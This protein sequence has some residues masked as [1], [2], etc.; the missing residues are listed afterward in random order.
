MT[1]ERLIWEAIRASVP[2]GEA[3]L[4]VYETDFTVDTKSDD[5]PLTRADMESHTIINQY[6]KHTGIPILSPWMAPK[7]LSKRMG[8]LP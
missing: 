4:E 2:A 5:S 6:L 8:S 7:S 3:I 1:I